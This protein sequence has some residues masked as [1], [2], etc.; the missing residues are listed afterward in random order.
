MPA[1]ILLILTDQQRFDALGAAGNPLIRTPHLDRL[2]REGTRFETT[3]TP[4]PVCVPARASLITGLAPGRLGLTSH[5]EGREATDPEAALPHGLARAGYVTRGI[6]KMHFTPGGPDGQRYGMQGLVL[7]EEMRFV[8]RAKGPDE[9][10]FDDYDRHLLAHG[11]WGWEKPPEIG[12]NEIK[13]LVNPLPKAL[14]VTQWCGDETVRWLRESAPRSRP[15]FLWTSFVKPHAPFD[16][17]SH[18]TGLYDAEAMP[19]PQ[20]PSARAPN[21]FASELTRLEEWDLYSER[22]ARL[23]KANY[24]ANITFIDEQVGRVLDTL[25]ELGLAESTLVVFTSDHGEMLGD[26][27]LWFK[28]VGYE[29]SLRVPLILRWPGRVP[30]GRVMGGVASLLDLHPTLAAAAGLPDDGRERPGRNLL[31][32]IEAGDAGDFSCAEI[33]HRGDLLVHV[34]TRDWK[35]LHHRNGDHE[36]LYDLRRDPHETINL[37]PAPDHAAMR[38]ELRAAAAAWLAR[39]GGAT[40]ALGDSGD[41][42]TGPEMPVTGGDGRSARPFSRFPWESRVPPSLLPDGSHPWWWREHGPDLR[43][44]LKPGVGFAG[45]TTADEAAGR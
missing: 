13:P 8:R 20:P 38:R 10:A 12:Y 5:G 15:F 34:R 11:C 41:L 22:A 45:T 25:D 1:N 43:G 44:L 2:S 4:C 39:H 42:A 32:L 9:V 35:Y 16:C 7:S 14:H 33:E 17:P 29:P 28:N 37:A 18:L 3:V 27:G 6:G 40:G 26:R 23:A 19:A 24:Y 30:A 31:D 21:R 36:E